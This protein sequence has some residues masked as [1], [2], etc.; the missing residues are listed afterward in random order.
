MTTSARGKLF[1]MLLLCFGIAVGTANAQTLASLSSFSGTNGANPHS[2]LILGS[3][4]NFYGTTYYGGTYGYG[5]VF[6]MTPGGALTVLHNF[7]NVTT[8]GAYPYGPLVQGSDGNFYGTTYVGGRL[9]GGSIFKITSS[10][11]FTLVYSFG[12]SGSGTLLYAGLVQGSDG[13]FYGTTYSGGANNKGTVFQITPAG[14][15]TTIYNFAGT[16]GAGP[17]ATMVFGSDG[18]LYGTTSQGGA[19]NLGAVFSVTT[20]GSELT[21]YSFSGADG[22]TPYAG[23]VQGSDGNFYGTTYQGG[24]Y[25]N[26][27]I[28]QITSAGSLTTLHS[29]CSPTDCSDGSLPYASL[30]Q[31]ADGNFYGVGSSGGTYGA[32]VLFKI[33]SSGTL[34]PL[35]SFT[36]TDGRLPY[37]A[38]TAAPNGNLYGTTYS[39]GASGKGTVYTLSPTPYQFTPVAPCRLVDTRN[40]NPIRGGTAQAF[41]LVQLA[42]QNGCADLSAANIYSLNVTLIPYN[43]QP[44][45]YL[46]IWPTG[47]AQPTIST[48]NSYDGRTKANAAIVPS[49]TNGSVSVYVSDLTDVVLDIDGYFTTVSQSTL[50]FFPLPPCRV[51]DTRGPNGDLGGPYLTHGVERDF[52]IL[53][54][55]CNIPSSAEAY[56]LNFTVLPYNHQ[57]LGYLTVWPAG[58]SQPNVSTLNNP[59]ATYVANAAIVPAGTGGAVAVY[60]SAN[61]QLLIDINGYFAPAASGGLSIYPSLPCRVL[62][63]RGIGSGQPFSGTLSPSVNVVTSPC[64]VPAAAQAYVFNATVLPSPTLNYLTLWPDS[65]PQPNV[66]TL[67]A[68]DGWPASNMAV[69]PNVNGKIDAY[70]SGTTQLILDISSYFAP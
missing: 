18:N 59:T 14:S 11:A 7:N 46:T 67:N 57:A 31:A 8:D 66:S 4:G 22:K 35:H 38:L 41:N 36:G 55:T 61:T 6:Q 52:P 24:T 13:N 32:G 53:E 43:G 68:I 30:M 27:T 3:D 20:A 50:E 17:Y 15:L 23:L 51:A 54:S 10:G 19:N 28:F 47:L 45:R 12:G 25:N 37:A 39:G 2:S 29:L 33:T 70:A 65:K 49:G 60:P 56:S 69:V 48:M 26:G 34:T 40:G 62:D 63:T 1:C 44:V 21:L 16:D 64:A 9:G 42:Q 58:G 5:T